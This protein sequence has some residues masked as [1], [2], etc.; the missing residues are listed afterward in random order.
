MVT[1]GVYMVARCN[2]LFLLSPVTMQVIAFTGLATVL[3][4]ATIA[5]FQN[6]IKKVL[7]YST[8]S[9]LG[10]MFL[11][12]GVGSFT[13]AVFHLTTHAFFKALLFLAAGSI[14][15]A[16]SGEQ[17]IRKMGGLSGKLRITFIT[18]LIATLAISGIPPLSGFFS[19]DEILIAVYQ[20][21]PIM[22]LLALTGALLTAFYIFRLLFLVFSGTFRGSEE[23]MK[24]AHESPSVMT[25]PL[26]ILAVLAAFGGFMGVPEMFG[27]SHRME[28]YLS[29]VFNNTATVKLAPI[30]PSTEWILLII[31]LLLTLS[32][33]M[34]TWMIYS[35]KQ[36]LPAA[37]GT[38]PSIIR[39]LISRK[40][41]VDEIYDFLFVQPSLWLSD[42]FHKFLE[43][44]GIDAL[45]NGIGNLVIRTGNSLRLIQTG[46][47]GFY[48]FMMVIGIILILLFNLII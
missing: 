25:V 31:T 34:I 14:I 23:Q 20:S 42:M 28:Q 2:I 48:M 27:G 29:P 5:L 32:I 40:F 33:I 38:K 16:L 41:Y 45:V 1:A 17:D 7:A 9:Q 8:I 12:L 47:T 24:H 35:R 10:Y 11:G 3:L 15:H 26:M 13:G 43:V 36:V 22:W 18:F 4:A 19:K 30:S 39:N 6:D 21:S 37:E 46:H 44:K